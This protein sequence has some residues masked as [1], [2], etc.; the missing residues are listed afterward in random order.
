ME[1][2][3]TKGTRKTMR[4]RFEKIGK[5]LKH[6]FMSSPPRIGEI[7]ELDGRRYRVKKVKWK[8]DSTCYLVM[9]SH[10]VIVELSEEK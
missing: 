5:Y 2:A 3:R 8:C 6:F 10:V 4:V 1:K 7:V 9:D